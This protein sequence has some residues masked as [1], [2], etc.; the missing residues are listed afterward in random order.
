MKLPKINLKGLNLKKGLNTIRLFTTSKAPE[1]A[2][3]AALLL[4]GVTIFETVRAT[5]KLQ[6]EIVSAEIEKNAE[7]IEKQMSGKDDGT[8]P[9][10]EKLTTKEMLLIH[11]KCYWLVAL[12]AVASGGLMLASVHFSNKKLKATSVALAAAETALVSKENAI[13]EVLTGK[14]QTQVDMEANKKMLEANP[15]PEDTSV[16]ERSSNIGDSLIYDT[17]LKRYFFSDIELVRAA[18]NNA[19]SDML[20]FNGLSINDYCS[21]LGINDYE[22]GDE[23]GWNYDRKGLIKATVAYDDKVNKRV[24]VLIKHHV[25]PEAF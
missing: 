4:M 14:Q 15:A 24:T 16:I 12:L 18:I 21:H 3:G 17:L 6:N 19:N 25:M 23:I 5:K 13:A 11:A 10:H 7:R 20:Q 1:L 9:A 2:A 22:W 8:T